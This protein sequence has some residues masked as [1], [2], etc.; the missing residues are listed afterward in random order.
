MDYQLYVVASVVQYAL[1]KHRDKL[2]NQWLEDNII[3]PIQYALNIDISTYDVTAL[4]QCRIVSPNV[5]TI[6]VLKL[7]TND[8]TRYRVEFTDTKVSLTRHSDHM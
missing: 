7:L 6:A 5:F 2:T 1:D 3:Y 8:T 4:C